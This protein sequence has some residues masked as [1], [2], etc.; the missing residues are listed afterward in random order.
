VSG[1]RLGRGAVAAVWATLAVGT[2][3]RQI[4]RRP[5]TDVRLP[6]ARWC[7]AGGDR[8]VLLV[9]RLTRSRC[10][11]RALVLRELHRARARP[12]DLVIGVAAPDADFEAHAWLEDPA[13]GARTQV[14]AVDPLARF[15]PIL[16]VPATP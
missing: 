8:A 11:V 13:D 2:A 14:V 9:L 6:S 16:R 1:G 7:A 12:L 15:T 5:V 10:L 3:R 4:D